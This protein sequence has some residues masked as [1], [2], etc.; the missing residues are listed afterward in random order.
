M[1]ILVE[2]TTNKKCSR[3]VAHFLPLR[4]HA[5][6]PKRFLQIYFDNDARW[7]IKNCRHEEISSVAYYW[8]REDRINREKMMTVESPAGDQQIINFYEFE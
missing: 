8:L 1:T 4:H 6:V 2:E 5:G 3:S 7:R